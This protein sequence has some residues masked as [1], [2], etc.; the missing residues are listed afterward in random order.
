MSERGSNEQRPKGNFRQWFARRFPDEPPIPL[1]PSGEIQPDFESQLFRN[2]TLDSDF[3]QYMAKTREHLGRISNRHEQD[4]P[5][6]VAQDIYEYEVMGQEIIWCIRFSKYIPKHWASS[7]NVKGDFEKA[8]EVGAR[9]SETLVD[10]GVS[11]PNFYVAIAVSKGQKLNTKQLTSLL[12]RPYFPPWAKE[13]I[14]ASQ[15]KIGV[16]EGNLRKAMRMAD[17]MGG[18]ARF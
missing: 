12:V 1:N 15:R 5:P 14:L 18:K 3:D 10:A 6:R 16:S 8:K 17:E 11:H 13:D 7:D 2:G 4:S 9:L